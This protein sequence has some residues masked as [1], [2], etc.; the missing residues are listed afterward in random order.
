MHCPGDFVILALYFCQ[1]GSD[2]KGF[3]MR[4][5]T[6][7]NPANYSP[8]L[9]INPLLQMLQDYKIL[10]EA[11]LLSKKSLDDIKFIK[12]QLLF[13]RDI[14]YED[15][16]LPV[17]LPPDFKSLKEMDARLRNTFF[18]DLLPGSEVDDGAV[19]KIAQQWV[20]VLQALIAITES[21]TL[22]NQQRI[23]RV[24]ALA[25]RDLITNIGQYCSYCE[26]P[27]AA[28]LAV[29]HM[30]PKKW[31]P[32]YAV[33]WDNFLLACPICNSVKSTKPTLFDGTLA[34]G[35]SSPTLPQIAAGAQRLYLWPSD[36]VNY[37]SFNR[38][39]DYEL[40]K[41]LYRSG[42][43]IYASN[44][45][46]I[47]ELLAVV[48]E[49]RIRK[50]DQ[51]GGYIRAE[52]WTPL[53]E[54]AS[55]AS[56]PVID[57]L[58]PLTQP[59]EIT[60]ANVSNVPS[61]L[62]QTFNNFTNANLNNVNA[63]HL[64]LGVDPNVY[65]TPI[66]PNQWNLAQTSAFKISS[67]GGIILYDEQDHEIARWTRG[68]ND[69]LSVLAAGNLPKD[70]ATAIGVDQFSVSIDV[71]DAGNS[72]YGL[73]VAKKYVLVNDHGTLKVYA[74]QI[75]SVELRLISGGT[76]TAT[77]VIREIALNRNEPLNVKQSDRRV[78]RRTNTLFDALATL[79]GLEAAVA[80]SVVAQY[81]N[82]QNDL[83]LM[84]VQTAI[85][86]GHWSVWQWVFQKFQAANSFQSRLTGA[87]SNTNNFP[88][89]R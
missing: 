48:G 87:L 71:V 35:S 78:A 5:V 27:L 18:R 4:P 65:A 77:R 82:I 14:S 81:P 38:F 43:G 64:N 83:I 50:R 2:Q 44:P 30:L 56:G 24:Y 73:S 88:G 12:E 33:R 85:L 76:K 47:Q 25:R 55:P 84:V 23:A 79:P 74:D 52:V 63:F 61:I 72:L 69:M 49:G 10:P 66:S 86:S 36:T 20:S 29:E 7:G 67:L 28:S 8:P 9:D 21:D 3:I 60:S 62:V 58:N 51:V 57:F 1:P 19:L 32:L 34:S 42:G 39:F 41:V 54:I 15:P 37:S 26:M 70:I 53:F 16:Q 13:I 45:F 59:V 11:E 75:F 40:H 80:P 46:T 31:F 17:A 68:V 22:A 89:T 6:R